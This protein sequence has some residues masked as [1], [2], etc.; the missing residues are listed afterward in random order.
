MP[1]SILKR[2]YHITE[3]RGDFNKVVNFLGTMAE[4]ESFKGAKKYN[5]RSSASGI[6]HFLVGNGG[7][8]NKRGQKIKGGRYTVKGDN[9]TSSFQTAQNR[10]KNMMSMDKYASGISAQGLHSPLLK[11]LQAN[12]PDDLSEEEQAVLAYANL[13][14]KGDKFGDFLEGKISGESLYADEWVT[15]SKVHARD[16]ISINWAN[17][18]IRN[19]GKNNFKYFGL[20]QSETPASPSSKGEGSSL[21]P[22]TVMTSRG[23]ISL[24][25]E[26]T[27]FQQDEGLY[28]INGERLY[29]EGG[30]LRTPS[31]TAAEALANIRTRNKLF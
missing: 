13:K 2:L 8:Y 14:M 23:P 10:L 6:F 19:K 9:A 15:K 4:V 16:S 24:N 11:I 17:A 3:N 31:S 5:K 27:P 1:E 21:R 25:P 26:G 12:T 22:Q 28:T 18:L 30:I 7:G 29:K 20:S